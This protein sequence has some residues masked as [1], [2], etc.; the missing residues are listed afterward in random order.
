MPDERRRVPHIVDMEPSRA[1]DEKQ[2]RFAGRLNGAFGED[3]TNA[4]LKIKIAKN[5]ILAIIKV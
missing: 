1:I 3:R 4:A 5:D 2:K